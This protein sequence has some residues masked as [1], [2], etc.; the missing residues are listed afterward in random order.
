VTI[1]TGPLRTRRE[2]GLDEI[3][4]GFG[5]AQRATAIDTLRDLPIP[6]ADR[7]GRAGA[8]EMGLENQFILA[9]PSY[10]LPEQRAQWENRSPIVSAADAKRQIEEAGL[11]GIVEPPSSDTRQTA[12]DLR[13]REGR[14]RQQ[15]EA[16]I[17]RRPDSAT[18][19]ALGVAT[20]L[21]L[22]FVDP[23]N[24]ATAFVPVIGPARYAALLEGAGSAGARLGIRAG[25]GAAEGAAGAA[26]VEPL[27]AAADTLEGARYTFADAL[28]AVAYGGLFG[29]A[30]HSL[31]GAVA[32]IAAARAKRSPLA[33]AADLP[34]EVRRDMSQA[35]TAAL[36]EGREVRAGELL[37]AAAKQDPALRDKIAPVRRPGA[38]STGTAAGAMP[39]RADAAP[40]ERVAYWEAVVRDDK[41]PVAAGDSLL[42]FIRREGGIRTD[43]LQGQDVRAALQDAR[44][45]PGV[46]NNQ[47]GRNADD[48][49]GDAYE[50]GFFGP[51]ETTERPDLQALY[52]ALDS[53]AR[54]QRVYRPEQAVEARQWEESRRDLNRMMDEAGIPADARPADAARRL[55]E[56]EREMQSA[57][58]ARMAAADPEAL[59]EPRWDYDAADELEASREADLLPEPAST[60]QGSGLA[61]A[62]REAAVAR[63][64]F[65]AAMQAGDISEEEGMA[66]LDAIAGASD[67]AE[68]RAAVYR[69]GAMC[70]MRGNG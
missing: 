56:F 17:A 24:V 45:P 1:Y 58:D 65:D 6:A 54:G 10:M 37:D 59:K 62:E 20:T 15:R 53:E 25:V 30:L 13:I 48:V 23:L 19:G 52:D 57:F 7:A 44:L 41:P 47:S 5:E 69:N 2:V 34:P 11:A 63:E 21:L 31:G 3:A 39:A 33:A 8:A 68:V 60:R 38:E 50:A 18:G 14:A 61:V 64:Q 26:L 36:I 16:T 49:L 43:D 9:D 35:A 40:D 27:V 67:L 70:I 28:G 55:A 66:L 46:I 51:V 29:G 12:V 22:Q 42:Q 32:D 4:S